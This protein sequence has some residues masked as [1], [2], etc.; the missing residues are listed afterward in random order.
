MQ[1]LTIGVIGI[2]RLGL[3]LA[4]NFER[5]G[6]AVWGCDIRD[7]YVRQLKEGEYN[8]IEPEIN[9]LLDNATKFH[10]TTSLKDTV[11]NSN[12]LYITVRTETEPDGSYDVSQ[13][14]SV[15]ESLMDLGVQNEPKT[16]IINCNVNPGYT[17][18]VDQRLSQFNY[19]VSFNPEWVAQGTIVRN[20]AEPDVIVIG[21]CDEL[22]GSKIIGIYEKMCLNKPPVYRMDSLSAEI[23]KVSLNCFLT[24]K[25]TFANM[26]GDLANKVG[27]NADIILKAIGSDS[28]I[29]GKYFAHGF[30]YGGP[31]FPRDNRA[32][33]K[34]ANDHDIEPLLP[35][36][37]QKYNDKHLEYQIDD[38]TAVLPKG[39]EIIVSG[40]TYKPGVDILEESQQ[41]LY[42]KSLAERGFKVIVEDIASV[43]NQ[44]QEK[45]GGLFEYR[46]K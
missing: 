7:D 19:K 8:T 22:E 3:G 20:Q 31:C 10:P 28:R 29:G 11:E 6:F 15:V 40:V 13:A 45:Y 14:D 41:L 38:L 26:V 35:E 5:S 17:R 34:F 30:G 27:A 39:Q 37:T 46:I 4:L 44:V 43:C 12:I 16:L 18:T 21:E 1:N 42:A 33:I 23:T 32:M 24:T 2:G 25:I 36:A 9:T